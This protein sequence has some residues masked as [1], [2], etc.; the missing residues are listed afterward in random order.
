MSNFSNNDPNQD[1]LKDAF[2]N[3]SADDKSSDELFFDPATGE[4]RSARSD[5]D[6][7]RVPAT[8]MAREGFFL[9]EG[10]GTLDRRMSNREPLADATPASADPLI[11][12]LEAGITFEGEPEELVFDGETGELQATRGVEATDRVPATQMAREGFFSGD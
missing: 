7:D 3:I 5:D 12:L 9:R 8:Q 10:D 6:S 11:R 4:L 2:E 1:G